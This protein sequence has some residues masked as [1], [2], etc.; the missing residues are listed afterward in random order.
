MRV[1]KW[2]HSFVSS[3]VT[4]AVFHNKIGIIPQRQIDWM[5]GYIW[6]HFVFCYVLWY[7]YRANVKILISRDFYFSRLIESWLY[8]HPRFALYAFFF[9]SLHINN[10][11]SLAC[12]GT[13]AG[14]IGLTFSM[15]F[16]HSL[17]RR[18]LTIQKVS[19]LS[20]FY[21]LTLK[22]IVSPIVSHWK[23]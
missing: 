5:V 13:H 8:L 18:L 1:Q 10:A 9:F 23:V 21:A 7:L 4:L 22:L 16:S 3:I 11:I 19:R 14:N 2:S 12:K 6:V 20:F 17:G 15:T